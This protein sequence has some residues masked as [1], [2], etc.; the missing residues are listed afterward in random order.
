[1]IFVWVGLK[2]AGDAKICIINNIISFG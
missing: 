1:V 2:K